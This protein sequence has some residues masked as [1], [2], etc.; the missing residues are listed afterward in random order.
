MKGFVLLLLGLVVGMS[1]VT[2]LAQGSGPD[3]MGLPVVDLPVM[4]LAA[5]GFQ[6][7]AMPVDR[8]LVTAVPAAVS[9]TAVSTAA[10]GQ[11]VVYTVT[12]RNSGPLTQ[13]VTLTD[14]LPPQVELV[15]ADSP[16]TYNPADRTL[17]WTGEIPPG[18]LDY[19]L[20]SLPDGLPYLDLGGYGLPNLCDSFIAAGGDCDET[21]VTFNLGAE[22]YSVSL[23][24]RRYEQI[25]V[26][27]NGLLFLDETPTGEAHWLPTAT[28]PGLR[29]AGL[30]QD[31]DLTGGGRWHAAI[32]SGYLAGQEVFYAQWQDAPHAANPDLTSRFAIALTVDR[33]G[34]EPAV[35][36]EI[37]YLLRP[38]LPTRRP[39]SRRVRHRPARQRREARFHLRLRRTRCAPAQLSAR[40]GNHAALAAPFLRRGLQPQLRLPRTSQRRHPGNGRQHRHHHLERRPYRMG[41]PLSGYPS[42]DLFAAAVCRRRGR[43]VMD[44]SVIAQRRLRHPLFWP[45][46]ILLLLPTLGCGLIG[47]VENPHTLAGAAYWAAATTT[48]VPTETRFLGTTTPVYPPT[49]VPGQVTLPPAWTTV[50][51]LFAATPTPYWVTTTPV[52]ITETPQPPVTTTPA[53]P[54][55]GFTTPVPQTTPYYRVGSFYMHSDV[56]IG[57]PNGLVLRLVDWQ[58]TPSPRQAEASFYYFT[59]RLTNRSATAAVVPLSD[60]LFIRTV[61]GG[62]SAA[63]HRPLA[64]GQRAAAGRRPAAGRQPTALPLA[65]A[66]D[67]AGGGGH[68]GPNG[69][70]AGDWP[71]DQLAANGRAPHLVSAD[72]R[73]DRPPPGRRAT[74]AAHAHRL[75]RWRPRRPR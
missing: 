32:L 16:L 17:H 72:P 35:A 25:Q 48:A 12:L 64:A 33:Q 39:H 27:T 74:A 2:A 19:S 3:E 71:A 24:G 50:T 5:A 49:A 21:A 14:V 58:T 70:G 9:K 73:S 31:L 75:G 22:G 1:G 18:Q 34:H 11:E 26:S 23:Y 43:A 38:H 56:H 66:G 65:A 44:P 20:T 41:H 68:H 63:G 69:P 46:A 10:P 54:I 53:L 57:G 6:A 60:L 28:A 52:Y 36:G 8:Q 4:D 51:P 47:A 13:T 67:A 7:V 40:A 61:H 37:F 42:P 59:F 55:I 29:L 30:W 45:A 62:A 15:A